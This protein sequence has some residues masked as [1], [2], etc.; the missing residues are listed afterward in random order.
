MSFYTVFRRQYCIG[1]TVFR[2]QTCTKMFKKIDM[3]LSSY[4]F[5]LVKRFFNSR[6]I[7]NELFRMTLKIFQNNLIDEG[8]DLIKSA[9]NKARF[10]VKN[11]LFVYLS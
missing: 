2:K 1:P 11:S 9:L 7:L 8:C 5:I 6:E 3:V 4:T 10:S